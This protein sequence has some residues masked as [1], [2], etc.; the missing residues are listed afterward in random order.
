MVNER[1]GFH[2]ATNPP[3]MM[4]PQYSPYEW[5]TARPVIRRGKSE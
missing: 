5:S 3:A 4:I 2:I 1:F